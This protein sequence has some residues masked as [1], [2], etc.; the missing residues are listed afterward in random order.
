MYSIQKTSQINFI[1]PFYNDKT[2]ECEVILGDEYGYIRIINIT[3][4]LQENNI[5]PVTPE[6][7]GNKNPYRIQDYYYKGVSQLSTM[8]HDF[9]KSNDPNLIPPTS[10]KQRIQIKAHN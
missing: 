4:F 3:G 10:I 6:L 9:T 7:I 1:K 5:V 2:K 8:T